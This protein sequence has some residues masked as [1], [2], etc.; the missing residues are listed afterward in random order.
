MHLSYYV[1]PYTGDITFVATEI[2]RVIGQVPL[3]WRLMAPWARNS[4]RMLAALS[5]VENGIH[6]LV[7]NVLTI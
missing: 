4:K 7:G 2:V 5:I 3:N 1:S 6:T